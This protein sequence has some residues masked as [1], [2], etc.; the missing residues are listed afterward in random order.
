MIGQSE[1]GEGNIEGFPLILKI[2]KS[3]SKKQ[4]LWEI[5]TGSFNS[6][7]AASEI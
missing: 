3:V 6:K 5:S 2:K 1:I 7:V 4:K